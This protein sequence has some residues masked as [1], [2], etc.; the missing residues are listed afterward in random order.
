MTE[1]LVQ[2]GETECNGETPAQH[3]HAFAHDPLSAD[4]RMVT[5]TEYWAHYYNRDDFSYEWN[6]GRLEVKPVAD[7]AQ[8]Q[9]YLWFLSLLKDYLHVNPI[10][11]MIGLEVGFRLHLATKTTV[12]KPDLAVVLNSNPVALGDKDRSY[13]GIF[14]L[15]IESLSSSTKGEVERDTVTKKLEYAAAGVREYY[16]LDERG[17]ETAFYRLS[18]HG[19]YVPLPSVNGVIQSQ[20]LPGLQFRTADLYRLPS[21]PALVTDP[22]YNTFASP[23]VRQERERAEQAEQRAESYAAVLRSLGID[24]DTLP[25]PSQ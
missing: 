6:N 20:V 18:A 22:V 19:V 24:I 5:E 11:R 25:A 8:F 21:A 1:K 16:I 12:R 7:Y 3:G 23:F 14:D 10:G 9:L 13:R 15:C 4:G 2:F 17:T